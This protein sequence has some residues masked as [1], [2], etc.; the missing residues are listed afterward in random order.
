MDRDEITA[1][2]DSALL[3][4]REMASGPEGWSGM[5]DPFPHWSLPGSLT[6]DE[7]AL[8]EEGSGPAAG[9]PVST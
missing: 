5:D 4:D 2:L 8:A 1:R 6:L 7:V 9:D 3:S